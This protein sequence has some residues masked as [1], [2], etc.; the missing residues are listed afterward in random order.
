MFHR[1]LDIRFPNC[2]L[3]L[4]TTSDKDAEGFYRHGPKRKR[5]HWAWL[6]GKLVAERTNESSALPLARQDTAKHYALHKC[7][8]TQAQSE[9]RARGLDE[10]NA[11][12][13]ARFGRVKVA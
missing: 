13:A 11:I 4:P 1:P 8:A 5:P 2:V 6:V 7:G 9:H 12:V 3:P 10:F